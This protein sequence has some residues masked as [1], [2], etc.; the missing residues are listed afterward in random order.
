M[1]SRTPRR[2]PSARA[3]GLGGERCRANRVHRASQHEIHFDL[4]FELLPPDKQL[5]FAGVSDRRHMR[6]EPALLQAL[7][8][9]LYRLIDP[10]ERFFPPQAAIAENQVEV[11]RQ[12]GHVP[13][14]EIDR[15]SAL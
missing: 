10:A 6:L 2:S 13:N 4:D 12:P 14:E 7:A 3:R 8:S 15:R 11:R 9:A 5:R 1:A